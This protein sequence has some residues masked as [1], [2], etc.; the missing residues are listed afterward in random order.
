VGRSSRAK[1][2]RRSTRTERVQLYH[3]TSTLHLP[4][5]ERDGFIRTTESNVSFLRPNAGPAVV[6]LMDSPDADGADHG[7]GG[8]I[9][10]KKAVR[11]TVRAHAERWADWY[12]RQPNGDAITFASMIRTGGG[13]EAASH[14]WVAEQ[15]IPRDQW[16]GVEARD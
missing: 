13:P 9:V 15:P 11:I 8:S 2:E 4:L 14:W 6:W 10:D 7:L 1:R 12:K 16:V 3:F 5:I